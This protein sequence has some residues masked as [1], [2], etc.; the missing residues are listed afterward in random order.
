MKRNVNLVFDSSVFN[1]D[2]AS[3]TFMIDASVLESLHPGRFGLSVW[4]MGLSCSVRQDPSGG[5][6]QAPE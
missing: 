3:K 6:V 2:K 5:L 4:R 1:F